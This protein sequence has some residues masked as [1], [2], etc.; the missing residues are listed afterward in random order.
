MSDKQYTNLMGAI[1]GI[2][3]MILLFLFFI[4]ITLLEAADTA[5]KIY[6]VKKYRKRRNKIQRYTPSIHESYDHLSVTSYSSFLPSKKVIV[7]F[8]QFNFGIN[9]LFHPSIFNVGSQ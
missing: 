6:N 8:S 7:A 1:C 3:S 9:N 2:G 4:W 5:Y